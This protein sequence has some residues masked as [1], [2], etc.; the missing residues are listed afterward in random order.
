MGVFGWCSSASG[1][2]PPLLPRGASAPPLFTPSLLQCLA[3][4]KRGLS[5]CCYYHSGS[6]GTP[7]T[8]KG[9]QFITMI[10]LKERLAAISAQGPLTQSALNLWSQS[11]DLGCSL[12]RQ[13]K[14]KFS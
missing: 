13:N 5:V 3:Y 9:S 11:K 10:M 2:P 4:G 6:W 12:Q 14:I 1:P 8:E 7:R